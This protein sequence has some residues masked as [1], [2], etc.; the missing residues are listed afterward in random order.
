SPHRCLCSV[1]E[2]CHL[3]LSSLSSSLSF[4]AFGWE[5]STMSLA[6]CSL[7]SSYWLFIK[8]NKNILIVDSLILFHIVKLL[9]TMIGL[10]EFNIHILSE[11]LDQFEASPAP[12]CS[13]VVCMKDLSSPCSARPASRHPSLA[14]QIG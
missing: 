3:V 12:K 7:S 4:P 1:W 11:Y 6:S 13:A 10:G 14:L 8:S 9:D 5:D 2:H